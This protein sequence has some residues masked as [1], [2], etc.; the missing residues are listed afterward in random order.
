[1]SAEDKEIR[2]VSAR[3]DVTEEYSFDALAKG[4]ASGTISRRKALRLVGSA[5]L[6]A[7]VLTVIPTRHAEAITPRCSFGVGCDNRCTNTGGRDCRCV[8]ITERT[9]SGRRKRRCVRPCC[10]ARGCNS[11]SD[12]RSTEVCMHTACC[13]G[14][15]GVCVTLCTE[16][17]PNY[18]DTTTAQSD[19]TT[20]QQ[21]QVWDDQ[22]P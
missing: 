13:G 2:A 5:I 10:S 22:A 19:T 1:M 14:I 17:R 12:C 16:P 8:R 7:G 20:T 3:G 21:A 6:G 11:S 4:L 15:R 18:C 9:S